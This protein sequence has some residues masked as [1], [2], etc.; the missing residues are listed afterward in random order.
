MAMAT[1]A[2]A[3]ITQALVLV[4]QNRKLQTEHMAVAALA[5]CGSP[6]RAQLAMAMAMVRRPAAANTCTD[7]AIYV[8]HGHGHGAGPLQLPYM[9]AY[10]Q[11]TTETLDL[12]MALERRAGGGCKARPCQGNAGVDRDMATH[13]HSRAGA[14]APL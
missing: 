7:L 13:M 6:A 4:L 8:G 3:E 12:I 2:R 11:Q 10:G 9:H 14:P 1:A 5:R